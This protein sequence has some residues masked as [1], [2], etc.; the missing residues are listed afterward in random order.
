MQYIIVGDTK[1]YEGCLIFACGEDESKA[2]KIL[3]RFLKNP[4]DEDKKIMKG[5]FNI[6]L[7]SENEH[8]CWWLD[9]ID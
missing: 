4:T 7:Q 6:R 5:H 3:K 2:K 1:E 9:E 8:N